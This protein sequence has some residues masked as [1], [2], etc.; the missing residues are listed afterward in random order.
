MNEYHKLL[1]LLPFTI[2]LFGDQY[3]ISKGKKDIHWAWRVIMI[4]AVSLSYPDMV[5]HLDL[6][7]TC[8]LPFCF[9]DIVL[10]K[11]RG[12]PWDYLSTT[13]GKYWDRNLV[14]LNPWFLL[15]LR[16][17]CVGLIGWLALAI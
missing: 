9:F 11:L 1:T 6:L 8:L 4:V 2:E 3:L 15:V 5:L 12:K 14:R 7:L 16:V 10:N 13:N 17:L